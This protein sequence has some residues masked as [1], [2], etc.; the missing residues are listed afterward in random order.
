MPKIKYGI[1]NVH[2]A[3]ATI[4]SDGTA[5]YLTPVALPGARNVSFE[6]DGEE[7]I[8]YADNIKYYVT[9]A[10]N[11]YTGSLELAL[12]PDSFK[13]TI[14]GYL[15]D[16]KNILFE[17]QEA[18]TE[19]FALIGEFSTDEKHR[20]FVFYNCKASRSTVSGSTKEATITPETETINLTIGSVYNNSL[21]K[22]IPMG[23]TT[24]DT[25]D[26]DYESFLT[27]VYQPTALHT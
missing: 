5:T 12:I 14:L 27:T 13:E 4:A 9:E 19:P 11:G 8:W 10:N 24:E 7:V 26:A 16:A 15:R 23:Y 1:C 6:P 22:W 25:A 3:K 20:R 21:E 2:Y 18:E 17:D